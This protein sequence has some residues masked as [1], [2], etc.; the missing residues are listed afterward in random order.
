ML[1]LIIETSTECSLIALF[2]E[3]QCLYE[4]RFPQGIQEMHAFV[5]T[6]QS[7]FAKC[8]KTPKELSYIAVGRGPGSFTGTRIGVV[9]GQSLAFAHGTPLIGFFSQQAFIPDQD[10]DFTVITDAKMGA[11]YMMKGEKKGSDVRYFSEPERCL[12]A[13]L[14][15][16]TT[17]IC[18]KGSSLPGTPAVPNAHHLRR[19]SFEKYKNGDYSPEAKLQI[20]YLSINS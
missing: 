7:A 9:V 8:G 12:T 15:A 13:E 19:I 5:E 18:P 11:V 20:F 10:G 4:Y 2:E 6:L 3:A 1:S 14:P 17:L 16:A